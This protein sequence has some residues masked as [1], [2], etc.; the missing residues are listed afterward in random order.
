MAFK[1]TNIQFV[2]IRPNAGLVGFASCEVDG[3]YSLG[4]LGV[5]TI[6]GKPGSYRITYPCKKLT[7]GELIKIFSPLSKELNKSI[8]EAINNEVSLLMSKS[9]GGE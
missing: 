3:F 1:V 4:N 8:S 9:E 6:L 7:N 5:Y 2:P